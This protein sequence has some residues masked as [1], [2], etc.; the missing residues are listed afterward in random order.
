MLTSVSR[1][2]REIC[3]YIARAVYA[4]RVFSIMALLLTETG[5]F[6]VW[7]GAKY[8]ALGSFIFLRCVCYV[9]DVD[10]MINHVCV[11]LYRPLWSHRRQST[12]KFLLTMGASC[13]VA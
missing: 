6:E 7:P 12:S 4:L 8:A 3:A 1:M 9:Q 5:S 13:V 11:G 10:N 2:F